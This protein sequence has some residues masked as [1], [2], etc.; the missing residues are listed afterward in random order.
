[1]LV[2]YAAP[3]LRLGGTLVAW[4]GARDPDEEAAGTRAALALG[5]EPAEPRPV[6]PYEGARD[7]N[8][9]LYSKVGKT[10]SKFP[11]RPGVAA[12]RPLG[13]R[14]VAMPPLT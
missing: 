2:E 3:L 13:A 7:L 14:N 8:L 11:R 5:L 12:K 4:K 9:H 1:V 6:E 10:P